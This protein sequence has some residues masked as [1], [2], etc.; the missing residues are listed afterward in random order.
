MR[1]SCTS[2]HL[3]T[4]WALVLGTMFM[5]SYTHQTDTR[6]SEVRSSSDHITD[7]IAF[8]SRIY[9][10]GSAHSSSGVEVNSKLVLL[11]DSATNTVLSLS[12][13][14]SRIHTFKHSIL[15]ALIQVYL[16]Y[17]LAMTG[18]AFLLPLAMAVLRM[19]TQKTVQT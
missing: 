8:L 19:H 15:N 14:Y 1:Y 11:A 17:S 4:S 16:R 10:Y 2:N 13:L 12:L 6:F 9:F 7:A 3:A 5:Y 18:V